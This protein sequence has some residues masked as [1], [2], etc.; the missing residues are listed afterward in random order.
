ML[1]WTNFDSFAITYL[2]RLFQK[3]HFPIEVVLNS[4]LTQKGR[5]L[6]FRPQF[7]QNFLIK[8]FVL[9]YDINSPNFIYRLCLLLKLFSKMY[10][11]FYV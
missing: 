5:E 10:F 6:V 3:L 9:E 8:L 7:L 1:I 4:L 11:L 2:S